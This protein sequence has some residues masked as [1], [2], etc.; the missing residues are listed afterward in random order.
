VELARLLIR[1]GE[2]HWGEAEGWLRQVVERHPDNEPSRVELARL[3]IQRGKA[4]WDEAEGWL[5]QVVERYPN[6]GPSHV[7]LT[8]LLAASGRESEAQAILGGF[9]A[10]EPHN[11]IAR[12]LL[13]RLQAGGRITLEMDEL[14]TEAMER[15][16]PAPTTL[17]PTG[18]AAPAAETGLLAQL[19][20]RAHWQ[21]SL[22]AGEALVE[23]RQAAEQ[24]EPLAGVCLAWLRQDPWCEAPPQAW[25]W[26]LARAFRG[27]APVD[28]PALNQRFPE[29]FDLTLY[30]RWLAAPSA[31]LEAQ[32]GQRFAK[33]QPQQ[34]TLRPALRFA[35]AR[36]D[37]WQ[38][39]HEADARSEENALAVLLA[40]AA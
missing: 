12:Q 39:G 13:S 17:A 32:L 34:A 36:W 31:E 25:A 26:Q 20:Q 3:L 1:R 6:N 9:V 4:H 11:A 16:T 28:W 37:A 15:P 5:R 27:D 30:V 22:L 35:L 18:Q 7:V 29:Q 21:R 8:H 2:A 23:V 40:E 19:Q 38:E 24:G 33:L 14:A 10:R